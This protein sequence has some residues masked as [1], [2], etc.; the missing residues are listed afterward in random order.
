MILDVPEDYV[1]ASKNTGNVVLILEASNDVGSTTQQVS[2]TIA[3]HDNGGIAAL[4]IPNLNERELTAP[5][6]DLSGDPD[7]SGNNIRYQWQ[8]RQSTQTAWIDVS[9]A[10]TNARYT[11][12]AD[13]AGIVEYRVVVRYTDG[14]GYG[15]EVLSGAVIYERI[16]I[17]SLTSCS[18]TD[19]DQD[20]DGL[21][22]ICDL[23]GLNAIRYQMDGSGYRAS[24]SATKITAGCAEGGCKGYEL[25]KDLDFDNDASYRDVA[26]KATWTTGS[27]WQ[28]LRHTDGDYQSTTSTVFNAVF[29]GN[30]HTLSNLM[31]NRS[32]NAVGLFGKIGN[33]ARL[34]SV[35]L[36]DVD[37]RG[38]WGVGGL[39]GHNS[40]GAITNSYVIGSVQGNKQYRRFSR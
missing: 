16:N 37:V 40:G 19:I 12:P 38:N 8:S 5:S 13:T 33:Q 6:I 18:T 14:Q 21:I 39:A 30:N 4:G 28:P 3:K 32:A 17:A 15:E 35:G 34:N 7:G 10:G 26:N 29:E 24:L 31:I 20:D 36:I 22:E 9:V 25:N 23:E 1:S 2:I 27:G 11:I